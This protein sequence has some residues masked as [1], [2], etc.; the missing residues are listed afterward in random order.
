MGDYSHHRNLNP[1][2]MGIAMVCLTRHAVV[3]QP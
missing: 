1:A 2:P 3:E